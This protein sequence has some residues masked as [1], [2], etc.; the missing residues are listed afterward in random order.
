M[1]IEKVCRF[2]GNA[3]EMSFGYLSYIQKRAYYRQWELLYQADLCEQ[4]YSREKKEI[5]QDEEL[6]S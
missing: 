3:F 4:E 6:G 1:G 2:K 5:E